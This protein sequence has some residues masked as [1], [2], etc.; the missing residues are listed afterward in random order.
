MWYFL[1]IFLFFFS[2]RRRHTR[3]TRDW[4]SDVCSS[5]LGF[6]GDPD[7]TPGVPQLALLEDHRV[8]VGHLGVLEAAFPLYHDPLALLDGNPLGVAERGLPVLVVV[9]PDPHVETAGVQPVSDPAA[10]AARHPKVS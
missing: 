9:D 4:S 3:S 8:Q 2:S 5:D 10:A 6:G 7:Q 1:F